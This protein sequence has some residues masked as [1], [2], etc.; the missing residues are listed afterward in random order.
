MDN[1]RILALL[2]N[3]R[4]QVLEKLQ[5]K[6][7]TG[8]YQELY[9][10]ALAGN[11]FD[12][13]NQLEQMIQE[14]SELTA[15]RSLD[16]QLRDKLAAYA[17]LDNE[18]LIDYFQKELEKLIR[19]LTASGRLDEM[20]ALFIS[21]DY[22]YHYTAGADC[23]GQQ[24]YPLI[25]EPRYISREFDYTKQILFIEHAVNFQPAWLDCNEFESL[26]Y[27]DMNYE[28]EHL[29]QLHSRTLLHHALARLDAVDALKRFRNRPFSFYINEHDSEVMMWYRLG[30]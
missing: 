4:N 9:E 23:Y 20:Q 6:G 5:S 3:Q 15:D 22:Y 24:E 1:N 11:V 19:E 16:D 25:E 29:F 14:L 2:E 13:D 17:G 10:E 21:Y 7:V 8:L 26:L 27:L 28:L 30:A 18:A 12:F